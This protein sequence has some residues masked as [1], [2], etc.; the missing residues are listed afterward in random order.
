MMIVN[1]TE[2]EE[3]SV[4]EFALTLAK[5]HE[6]EDMSREVKEENN[7]KSVAGFLAEAA[8]IKCMNDVIRASER[9]LFNQNYNERGGDGGVDFTF[10]GI[11]FDVKSAP[12]GEGIPASRLRA[13]TA[14]MIILVN[15]LG[16]F[17][18]WIVYGFVPRVRFLASGASELKASDCLWIGMLRQILPNH[19]LNADAKKYRRNPVNCYASSIME[20]G[21]MSLKLNGKEIQTETPPRRHSISEI[22]NIAKF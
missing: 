8:A 4:E 13:S 19:F 22:L 7:R 16:K 6:T 11:T 17:K 5:V 21:R 20:C 18:G 14:D 9:I 12:R 3:R 15:S 10:A 2:H 1:L